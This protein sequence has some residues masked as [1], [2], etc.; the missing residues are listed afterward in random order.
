MSMVWNLT[1]DPT[2]E[3]APRI[4]VVLGKRVRPG[5]F[6]RVDEE[7]LEKA[8][9]IHKDVENGL[10]YIGDKPPDHYTAVKNPLA[11]VLG[12]GSR[13]HGQLPP[14]VEVVDEVKVE[15]EVTL[16]PSETTYSGKGKRKKGK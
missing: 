12:P 4:L 1:D 7:R 9:K 16:T 14:K 10:L 13:S 11:A 8:H 3:H 2:T 5:R 6:V 15:D